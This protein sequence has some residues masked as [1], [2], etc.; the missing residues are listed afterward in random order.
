M[1]GQGLL[2]NAV[3]FDLPVQQGLARRR[4]DL[5]QNRIDKE[6]LAFHSRVRQGFLQLAQEHPRR[7]TIM[8]ARR[9]EEAIAKRMQ[10]LV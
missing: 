6:T 1:K 10:V 7:M 8:N 3:L 2:V 4:R 5:N 9:S